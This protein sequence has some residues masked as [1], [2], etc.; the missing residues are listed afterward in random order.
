MLCLITH[1]NL[2]NSQKSDHF[3]LFIY[4]G[5]NSKMWWHGLLFFSLK[6]EWCYLKRWLLKAELFSP[7]A[8]AKMLSH[9][10]KHSSSN[11]LIWWTAVNTLFGT[12]ECKSKSSRCPRNPK[13]KRQKCPRLRHSTHGWPQHTPRYAN[14]TI[15]N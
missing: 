15:C 3:H 7:G 11:V 2:V 12:T 6:T 14:A 4:A 1:I 8:K 10:K 9:L 13:N 5:L